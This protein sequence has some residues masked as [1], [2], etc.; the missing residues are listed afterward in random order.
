[1]SVEALSYRIQRTSIIVD[2]TN[3]GISLYRKARPAPTFALP[4]A[5]SF[6]ASY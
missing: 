1:L 5:H 3:S 2:E 4:T 6:A